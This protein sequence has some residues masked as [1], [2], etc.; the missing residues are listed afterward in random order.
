MSW[1]IRPIWDND[2][3]MEYK[4]RW[5][6]VSP[7]FH[8]HF[9]LL[10]GGFSS[11]S[12]IWKISFPFPNPFLNVS[13]RFGHSQVELSPSMSATK[14]SKVLHLSNITHNISRVGSEMG[15]TSS[16][17]RYYRRNRQDVFSTASFRPPSEQPSRFVFWNVMARRLWSWE[18]KKTQR[19]SLR[20]IRIRSF[21]F[22]AI[23]WM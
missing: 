22:L 16:L 9:P 20:Y 4:P 10:P 21:S 3:D 15:W 23:R 12:H 19:P 2:A 1:E 6:H 14:V 8:L 18:A 17:V 11:S 13:F 5:I 7:S